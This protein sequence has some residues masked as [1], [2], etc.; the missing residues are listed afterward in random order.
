MAL[1]ACGECNQTISTTAAV[2]PS[3][4]AGRKDDLGQLGKP[5]RM[6]GCAIVGVG[7][8][9][10]LGLGAIL[11]S[12]T[13][14][15]APPPSLDEATRSRQQAAVRAAQ[16]IKASAREPVSITF[17][18]I[19]ADEQGE[20][21]CIVYRGRNGFGGMNLERV[22]VHDGIGSNRRVDWNRHCA[23]KRMYDLTGVRRMIS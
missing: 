7:F 15:Q 22:A 14:R 9:I 23:D 5:K 18:S 2:C 1:I 10:L 13:P 16:S 4:G 11:S 20:T 12:V 6:S 19:L 17:E 8:A 21:V 3:C